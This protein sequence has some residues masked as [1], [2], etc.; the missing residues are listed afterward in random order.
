MKRLLFLAVLLLFVASFCFSSDFGLLLN[1]KADADDT[2]FSYNPSFTPWFSWNGGKGLSVYL[3][4]VFSLEYV[5]YY[6][7]AVGGSGFTIP[8]LKPEISRFALNY[9]VRNIFLEA[10]RINYSDTL[11]FAASGLFD[12][13]RFEASLP[14]GSLS[15]GVYYT[16]LLYK[17]TAK[18]LMTE[19]DAQEY[20]E[21]WKW[22]SF[23]GYFAS[24]RVLAA[25]RWDMPVGEANS[26]SAEALVQFDLSG[27]DKFLH[28]Q[29]GE[30]KMDLV[31]QNNIGVTAGLAFEAMET[32]GDFSA[33]LGC[34]FRIWSDTPSS[35]NDRL[36][37][38]IKFTSGTWNDAFSAFKPISS[39][40][41]GMI[42]PGTNEG[43]ASLSSEYY[44][45]IHR[46]LLA[47]ASMRYFVGTYN[48]PSV[49]GHLYGCEIW[50]SVVWQPFDDLRVNL[51][52]GIFF[53]SMGDVYP[54]NT[55]I[56][57]KISAGLSLSI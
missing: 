15:A 13:L 10:G 44:I 40:T 18:I 1:Q 7:K 41:Q 46:T 25:L 54:D 2:L 21:P 48:D 47:D 32:K 57:W 42:F 51:G 22:G 37:T 20:A 27:S 53:P 9:R 3:S 36:T 8:V 28:S 14:S 50:T 45:R 26:L 39:V 29:Y 19:D 4:G 49:R 52:G 35:L 38:T 24:R 17:E 30:F 6:D 23:K 55:S 11:G 56:M 34:L 33:A 16:G 5:N 12:G 31:T 43:L